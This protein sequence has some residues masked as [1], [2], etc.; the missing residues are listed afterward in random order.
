MAIDD[1]QTLDM[2]IEHF[3]TERLIAA[4]PQRPVAKLLG[5]VSMRELA[6][7]MEVNYERLRYAMGMG[8]IPYPDVR[9]L[10]RAYFTKEQADRIKKQWKERN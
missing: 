1:R 6:D 4:L 7:D 5:L 3:G 8:K 10:R 9:L 2:L